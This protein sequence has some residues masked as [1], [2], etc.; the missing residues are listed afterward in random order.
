M[1]LTSQRLKQ[2]GSAAFTLAEILVASTLSVIVIGAL[3]AAL[4]NVSNSYNLGSARSETTGEA[5]MALDILRRDLS[6]AFTG[7]IND[8]G[9]ASLSQP[10]DAQPPTAFIT[11]PPFFVSP[12]TSKFGSRL[13]LPFEVNRLSGAIFNPGTGN[14]MTAIKSIVNAQAPPD[15]SDTYHPSFDTIAFVTRAPFSRQSQAAIDRMAF[16]EHGLSPDE[17]FS[18]NGG[19]ACLAAYYVAY[20]KNAALPQAPASMK[21]FR[22]F[23]DSGT[24]DN[25][26]LRGGRSQ[27]HAYHIIG[28]VLEHSRIPRLEGR[29]NNADLPML[30]TPVKHYDGHQTVH[31][32]PRFAAD[33]LGRI[34][35]ESLPEPPPDHL[36]GERDW[37]DSTAP[38]NPHSDEPIAYNVIRFKVV[39]MAWLTDPEDG[40]QFLAEAEQVNHAYHLNRYSSS[41]WPVV[42]T[43]QVLRITLTIIDDQTA[44]LLQRRS[45]WEQWDQRKDLKRVISAK[46]REFETLIRIGTDEM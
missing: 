23:R 11:K 19:D 5:R 14:P 36:I 35:Y 38:S 42:V 41:E 25:M 26:D 8:P 43:P 40:R 12:A 34:D 24:R 4:N 45:D 32:W 29:L 13:I 10:A 21:L 9:I 22:Y 30:L 6:A 39:P 33:S 20:T 28:A 2:Y 37:G 27:G 1:E 18:S 15:D 17:D 46:A 44:S 16:P 3:L 31:P 7:R